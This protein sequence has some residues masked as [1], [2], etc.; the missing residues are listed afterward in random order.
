MTQGLIA[1]RRAEHGPAARADTLRGA[2]EEAVIASIGMRRGR[3]AGRGTVSMRFTLLTLIVGLLVV[4]G[5]AIN[6]VWF[7]KSRET[8]EVMNDRFFAFSARSAARRTS[9]LF[10]P[11]EYVLRELQIGAGRGL[12][13]VE[14]PSAL[15]EQLV[16]VLRAHP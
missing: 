13:Q 12:Q 3:P 9:D 10:R 15:A 2:A 16:E 8:S 7:I 11:A 6:A 1:E 5:L 14:N 4:S